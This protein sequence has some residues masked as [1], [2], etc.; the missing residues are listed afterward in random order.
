MS[1]E[2]TQQDFAL[3]S[4]FKKNVASQQS[5]FRWRPLAG[6]T[7]Y[8]VTIYDRKL[9]EVAKSEGLTATAWTVQQPLPR[10]SVYLWQVRATKE[11]KEIISPPPNAPDAKFRVLGQKEWEEMEQLLS[12][13]AASHLVKGIVYNNYGLLDEA[14]REFQLLAAANPNSS[15]ARG[16]LQ[17]SNWLR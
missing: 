5:T 16:L 15:V 14:Q 11:E 7:N 4:P 13:A 3:L 2:P 8:T 6:A 9:N 10:D 1:T 17:Q 12:Q